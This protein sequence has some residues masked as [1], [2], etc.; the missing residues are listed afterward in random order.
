MSDEQKPTDI[1]ESAIADT[2]GIPREKLAELRKETLV[3][4]EDWLQKGRKIFMTQP[5]IAK[6]IALLKRAPEVIKTVLG[7]KTAPT[8]QSEPQQPVARESAPA[9]DPIQ[10]ELMDRLAARGLH[11][12]VITK[13]FR[14]SRILFAELDGKQIR[15]KV[16][17]SENF[18]IGMKISCR[19]D[20]DDVY[21]FHGRLP[22]RKGRLPL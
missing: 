18:V 15:V 16:R 8:T 11:L 2:L 13:L 9:E 5:G 6:I 20:H 19:H 1:E 12:A 21:Q 3:V 7:E 10:K 17:S 22:R 4:R 14:K